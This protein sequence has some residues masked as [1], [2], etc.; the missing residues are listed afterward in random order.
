MEPVL[1]V[2]SGETVRIRTKDCFSNCIAR[3]DQL[4][5]SI[6][7]DNIN[8]ATGPLRVLGAEP[9]D[10]LKVEILDIRVAA[11]GVMVTLPGFGVLEK[12]MT[13]ETTKIIPI[14]DGKAVLNDRVSVPIAPMIGVI[15]TAPAAEPVSTGTPGE[16][17]GNMDCKKIVKGSTLYLPV[18]V[19]GAML[20]LGDLHAVMGDGEIVG[21]GVEISGEVEV[22]VT[23]L[24]GVNLPTPFLAD[25]KSLMT[26]ASA[27][28]LEEAGKEAV[29]K[30]HRFLCERLGIERHEAGMLLSALGNLRIC[31]IVDPLMTA[32]MEIPREIAKLYS[33][34]AD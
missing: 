24:K 34:Q 11:Q 8:P 17:G 14:R 20:A 13:R 31:Q 18:A 28:V 29:R 6:N 9:G 26:I 30:M 16:H 32:R 19:P 15:G 5:S 1:T 3:E 25:G 4:L 27:P 21:C 2:P 7:W 22:R 33:F 10:I 12:E 23:V